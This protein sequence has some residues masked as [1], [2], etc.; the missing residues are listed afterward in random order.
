MCGIAGILDLDGVIPAREGL[1]RML[2]HLVHRGPDD[3][4][5]E[6]LRTSAGSKI[7]LGHTRLSI[8]DLSS[9]GH[10]PMFNNDRALVV[11]S[12]SEIYNYKTL[13]EELGNEHQFV[14]ESDTEVLLKSWQTWGPES[15]P[16]FMACLVLLSVILTRIPSIWRGTGWV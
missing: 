12:N 15:L 16:A 11:S 2:D 14:S 6:E 13:R 7:H 5:E 9:G 1:S 8:I 10:Q 3:R 4:G